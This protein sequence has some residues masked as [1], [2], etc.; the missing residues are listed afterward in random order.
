MVRMECPHSGVRGRALRNH[1]DFPFV[2]QHST[3]H[4]KKHELK[5]MD[6]T[7]TIQLN[8]LSAYITRELH[9]SER[10]QVLWELYCGK[11][12][13]LEVAESLGMEVRTFFY[14]TS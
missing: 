2:E 11:A 14:D 13:T 8:E 9:R 5:T 7:F 4:L 12:R 6:V 1:Q 3:K 10:P